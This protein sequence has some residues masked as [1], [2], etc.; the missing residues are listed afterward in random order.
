M[1]LQFLGAAG[2]VTGSR[3]LLR[4]GHHRILIDCGMFQGVKRLRERNRIPFPVDPGSLHAVVLTHAHLDH[5]G[6]LPALVRAGFKGPVYCTPGT[7]ALAEILLR[8]AAKLQEE[9]AEYANRKGFSKH[10]PAQPL[11]TLADAEEALRL[12]RPVD[13]HHPLD[14]D[15]MRLT[16]HHAGHIIGAASVHVATESGCIVFSGD[17]G[18]RTDPVL[19][20]PEPLPACDWLVTEST[21]GDRLHPEVDAPAV[22]AESVTRCA[23][24]GG[25]VVMP[26]FAVGRAQMILHLL[27]S[28]KQQGRIPDMP[29]VLDSPMASRATEVLLQFPEEHHLTSAQCRALQSEVTYIDSVEE[30]IALNHRKGPHVIVSA[31]GMA[32]GGRVLHHLKRLLPEPRNQVIFVGF[33]AP[34][35]RGEVLVHGAPSVKIHGEYVPVRAPVLN[36]DALSAHA[37]QAELMDWIATAPK[38]PRQVFVTHGEPAA[39][40]ALRLQVKDRLGWPVIVPEPME[41]FTLQP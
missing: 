9:D 25:V 39:S 26:A 24:R 19:N 23:Q 34:G 13:W 8:D 36:I 2:T 28:L 16:F 40:D 31:S 21:Y 12:L 30:S 29:I 11:Y 17:V 33:Q 3:Y 15:G 18:R 32:T 6:W 10:Q 1:E 27:V 41:K 4:R 37:D 5:S 20:P 7:R 14:I 38:A 35:T 22:L